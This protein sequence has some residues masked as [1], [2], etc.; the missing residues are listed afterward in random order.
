M[1]Y[2]DEFMERYYVSE[3]PTI[4]KSDNISIG[5]DQKQKLN[6]RRKDNLSV[7]LSLLSN[8]HEKK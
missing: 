2:M 5:S 7:S 1:S 3:R 8:L 4:R 6:D